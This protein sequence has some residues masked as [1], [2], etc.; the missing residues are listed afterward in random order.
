LL[1]PYGAAKSRT[2]IAKRLPHVNRGRR[3]AHESHVGGGFGI[4]GELYPEDLLV[5]VAAMRFKRPV[6]G[7]RIGANT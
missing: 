2:A 1:E 7:S 5:L 4:R 3:N 6:N